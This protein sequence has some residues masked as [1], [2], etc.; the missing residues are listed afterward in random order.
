M[1]TACVGGKWGCLLG[2]W[3]NCLGIGGFLSDIQVLRKD[4]VFWAGFLWGVIGRL[5]LFSCLH[6]VTFVEVYM[7]KILKLKIEFRYLLE[8]LFDPN[9]V[10]RS[11]IFDSSGEFFLFHFTILFYGLLN[12]WS[13]LSFQCQILLNFERVSFII[14]LLP[15]IS[16]LKCFLALLRLFQLIRMGTLLVIMDT[17]FISEL[18]FKCLIYFLSSFLIHL[19]ALFFRW[20]FFHSFQSRLDHVL[21]KLLTEFIFEKT[22]L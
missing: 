19:W 3:R 11:F 5:L 1:D 7:P 9:N 14:K 12:H 13:H 17:Q 16:K 22:I 4:L 2:D 21:I 6:E 15:R 18:L 20:V 10:S 8:W